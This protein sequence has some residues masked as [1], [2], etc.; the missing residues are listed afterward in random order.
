MYLCKLCQIR[1][2]IIYVGGSLHYKYCSLN[3]IEGIGIRSQKHTINKAILN[4]GL[5]LFGGSELI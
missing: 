5:L 3:S 1:K 2:L 4:I